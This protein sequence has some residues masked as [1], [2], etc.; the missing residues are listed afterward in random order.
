MQTNNLRINQLSDAAYQWY[1]SY[2]KALDAKD[3]QAYGAFLAETA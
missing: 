3:I 1:L 2:L